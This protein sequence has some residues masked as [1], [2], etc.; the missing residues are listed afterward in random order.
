MDDAQF[1]ELSELEMKELIE[2]AHRHTGMTIAQNKK[3]MM[4]SRLR[5]RLRAL[6]LHSYAE[7]IV[8]LGTHKQEV[9]AFVNQ[10]TTNETSF[11]RTNRVW[12]Y[13]QKE[14]LPNWL[15]KHPSQPLKIWSGAASSGEEIYT[16]AMCC[17]DFMAKNPGFEFHV[18]GTDISTAVLG[19]GEKGLYHGKSVDSLKEHHPQLFEKYF[20]ANAEGYLVSPKLRQQV[21]FATHNLMTVHPNKFDLVFLRNVLIYF[22]PKEQEAILG[23]VSRSMS[24]EGQIILGES[25]SLTGLHTPFQFLSPQVYGKKGEL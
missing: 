16:I 8:Y 24:P 1:H 22:E 4:Q 21:S 23:N 3:T 10:V 19:V 6:G 18:L 9:Q 12:D 20:Q 17:M 14:F 25:E 2:L 11:F 13:F 5:P 15:K 7:Y